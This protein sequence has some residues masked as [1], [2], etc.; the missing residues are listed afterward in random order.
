MAKNVVTMDECY[1]RAFSDTTYSEW[2]K[3]ASR[4]QKSLLK[5]IYSLE[6]ELFGDLLFEEPL[7]E[8]LLDPDNPPLMSLDDDLPLDGIRISFEPD[9]EHEGVYW[10]RLHHIV[11]KSEKPFDA[12]IHEVL[13]AYDVYYEQRRP[14]HDFWTIRLY[15]RLLK[16]I[17]NLDQICIIFVNVG[18]GFGTEM[19]NTHSMLFLLKSLD[20]DLRLD[21]PLGTTFGY[22][23][24]ESISKLDKREDAA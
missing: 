17:S 23:L 8:D 6:S 3:I 15:S 12:V 22:R 10:Q 7:E 4:K 9:F 19:G 11:M 21:I 20:I 18:V 16:K 1:L 13:H 5:K 2:Y 24:A 14:L